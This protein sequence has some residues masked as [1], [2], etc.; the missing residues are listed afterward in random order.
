MYYG[1]YNVEVKYMTI[2]QRMRA[3]IQVYYCEVLI[4]YLKYYLKVNVLS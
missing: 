2:V 1:V 4:F 3:G